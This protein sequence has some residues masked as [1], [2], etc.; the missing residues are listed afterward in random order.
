MLV[1]VVED[2]DGELTAIASTSASVETVGAAASSDATSSAC[3]PQATANAS[4]TK[5]QTSLCMMTPLG[6]VARNMIILPFPLTGLK[7]G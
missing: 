7:A 2:V 1:C 5:S 4:N 3:W 6:E